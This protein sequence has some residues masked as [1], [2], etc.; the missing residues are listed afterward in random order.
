MIEG[1][2]MT[3]ADV[4]AQ[5]GDGRLDDFVR[6][7]VGLVAREIMEAEVSGQ[8]GAQLG[9]LAPESRV[10]HRNGYRPR[11]WETR[12][13]EIELMI[14][15]TPGRR[16]SRTSAMKSTE[17]SLVRHR[18]PRGGRRRLVP[19][20]AMTSL[21]SVKMTRRP[22]ASAVLLA[23]DGSRS[24]RRWSG[25]AFAAERSPAGGLANDPGRGQTLVRRRQSGRSLFEHCDHAERNVGVER[26]AGDALHM[27]R[28]PAGA[29]EVGLAS[30]EGGGLADRPTADL[31]LRIRGLLFC[32][33]RALPSCWRMHLQATAFAWLPLSGSDRERR[34]SRRRD[35]D[36]FAHARVVRRGARRWR[37]PRWSLHR[38]QSWLA[39]ARH[40]HAARLRRLS[41][42]LPRPA[43][44]PKCPFWHECR[45]ERRVR[46]CR[47]VWLERLL[48]C[49]SR[50]GAWRGCGRCG[51]GRCWV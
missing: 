8:V 3:V 39:S 37:F 10:T 25:L 2:R 31:H 49:G 11:P 48:G 6:E 14:P 47:S 4:V 40:L 42:S 44:A 41:P 22:H 34:Q 29:G 51:C 50:G 46:K 23:V 1:Q 20:L 38:G 27:H 13:G 16:V 7:A 33:P 9:E 35:R 17:V 12:V 32:W 21:R 19:A 18:D 15:R 24:R 30:G 43:S 28:A 45:S 26:A 5:V 36:C